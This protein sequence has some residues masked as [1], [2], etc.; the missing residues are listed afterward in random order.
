MDLASDSGNRQMLPKLIRDTV[1]GEVGSL[2]Q[3]A[4]EPESHFMVTSKD[5]TV[6]LNVIGC[7]LAVCELI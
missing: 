3:H 5:W 2:K 6:R 7:S 1:G 4:I